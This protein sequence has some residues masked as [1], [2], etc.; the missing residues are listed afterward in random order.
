MVILPA[1]TSG[2]ILLYR[3]LHIY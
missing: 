1:K 2:F 3:L